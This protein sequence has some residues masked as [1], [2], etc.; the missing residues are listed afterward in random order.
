VRVNEGKGCE[1]PGVERYFGLLL[2]VLVRG[3]LLCEVVGRNSG[4]PLENS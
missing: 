3:E 1:L 4:C 2:A